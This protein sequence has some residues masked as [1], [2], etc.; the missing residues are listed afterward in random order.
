MWVKT[1]NGKTMKAKIK[2][3]GEIVDVYH[4]PQHGQIT[5]IYKESVFVNGR[6]WTEDELIFLNSSEVKE[7]DLEKEID[8]YWCSLFC[9]YK[10]KRVAF[11]KF[12]PVPAYIDEKFNQCENGKT[13]IAYILETDWKTDFNDIEWNADDVIEFARYFYELGIKAQKGE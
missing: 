7:V 10:M 9:D 1:K 12:V 6:I 5:N 2:E 13:K 8:N 4:E 11:H 3:T